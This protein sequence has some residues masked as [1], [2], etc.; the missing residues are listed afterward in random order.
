MTIINNFIIVFSQGEAQQVVLQARLDRKYSCC[1]IKRESKLQPNKISLTFDL[2]M[3]VEEFFQQLNEM[4]SHRRAIMPLHSE[5]LPEQLEEVFEEIR[6]AFE[7]LKVAQ[8]Q[9][10]QQN[11]ELRQKNEELETA[12]RL[13]ESESRRY[14]ELFN[15]AP[16]G[17]LVT[18]LEGT[19][20]EANRATLTLLNVSQR[21]IIGKSVFNF[22][23][24]QERSVFQSKLIQPRQGDWVREWEVRLFPNRLPPID[25]AV[26]VAVVRNQEYKPIALRWLLRDITERKRAEKQQLHNAFHDVLTGLPNRAL[27]MSRLERAVSVSKQHENY[28]FAVLFLD[29]DR[30]KVINDSLGH[31]FG[32]QL[33]SAI[34]LRLYSVLHSRATLADI[35]HHSQ[36]DLKNRVSQ[37]KI[38]GLTISHSQ[39]TR[40]FTQVQDV[41]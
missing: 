9:L 6:I 13:L 18:D 8:E 31:I 34:A 15:E 5:S 39:E 38:K 28:L 33:L 16:D 7:E 19:I 4:R 11:E 27:F 20:Q 35:L 23:V 40:F 2:A 36:Q 30:F 17:Y 32:D 22:I 14:Q 1:K 26:T 3:N 12:R 25:V 24:E 21:F 41:S 37:P 10:Y 29:L